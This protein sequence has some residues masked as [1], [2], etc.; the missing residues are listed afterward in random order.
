MPTAAVN[1]HTFTQ[2]TVVQAM[3]FLTGKAKTKP[4]FL[5]KYKGEVKKRRLF[6]D[7]KLVVPA[8]KVEQYL[9][10]RIYNART[11]LTR[12]AA[13]YTI[14]KDAVG[15][16][17]KKIDDFLKKQRIVRETDNQQ[18]QTKRKSRKVTKKG[19]LHFDLIELKFRDLPF[20]P[21]DLPEEKAE[22]DKTDEEKAEGERDPV[23]KGYI[24]SMVDALTSLSFFRFHAYKS[25]TEVTPI[26]KQAFEF[27]SKMLNVPLNR[28]VGYS[29]KGGEFNFKKYNTWGIRTVQLKRSSVVENKNSHMQRVLFRLA[30]TLKTKNLH[31]LVKDT[32]KVVNRTQSSLTKRSP[33]ENAKDATAAVAE[34]YNKKRGRD[35]GQKIKRRAL[36]VGNKVRTQLLFK[37][38]KGVG[39][40]AYKADQWS[41][42]TYVIKKK[43]G[44]SYLVNKKYRHRDELRL[45]A[46]Y[47]KESEKL[48][49]KREQQ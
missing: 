40:K 28:L 14:S 5:N 42:R 11:P 46:D 26:A 21:D 9:R 12:D 39:F 41:K 17:R 35:S 27:F 19:Q 13:F 16:S 1:R 22:K 47:D 29:D 3:K 36:V 31:Q 34:K 38:D 10:A 23:H 33:L 44:A 30:K 6:L 49:K 48:I 45:T 8:E 7:G 15:V 25:Y 37:K 43:R 24:F 4:N 2:K 18:P 32:Q 20:E